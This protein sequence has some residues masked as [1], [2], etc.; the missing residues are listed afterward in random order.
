MGALEA[1]A[2]YKETI[3]H[4]K[5]GILSHGFIF[6][7]YPCFE[8]PEHFFFIIYFFY[9]SFQHDSCAAFVSHLLAL[10]SWSLR[11]FRWAWLRGLTGSS[12]CTLQRSKRFHISY[13]FLDHFHTCYFPRSDM[14]PHIHL[15]DNLPTSLNELGMNP[16]VIFVRHFDLKVGHM[17]IS[18]VDMG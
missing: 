4:L 1:H 11:R 5:V 9:L 18:L 14:I 7:S 12:C 13:H 2:F 8:Q 6:F 10:Q 17:S 15:Y 3:T 16:R